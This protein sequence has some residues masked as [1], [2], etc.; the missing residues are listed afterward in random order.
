MSL[1]EILPLR[2]D[3]DAPFE[4]MSEISSP[5]VFSMFKAFQRCLLFVSDMNVDL[6][7][8]NGYMRHFY[9]V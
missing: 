6:D 4:A 7:S 8:M 1:S 5:I 3:S 9:T 2:T